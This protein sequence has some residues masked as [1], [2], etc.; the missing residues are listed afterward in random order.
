MGDGVYAS[1]LGA[2]LRLLRERG[3]VDLPR[4]GP[5]YR[6]EGPLPYRNGSVRVCLEIED[7]DFIE[8]PSI[9]ILEA[10]ADF[11]ALLP[12]VSA[13]G[14]FCYLA[15]GA[16]VLDRY[17]PEHAIAHCLD[18]ASEEL[19]RLASDPQYRQGEFQTEFGAS[20]SIGQLP[21]PW[22]VILGSIAP[23]AGQAN[24]F[25]MGPEDDRLLAVTS[26]DDEIAGL[27]QSRGWPA[28]TRA[29]ATCWIV[30]SDCMPTLIA[31]G[32]PRTVGEMFAWIKDWDRR[33]YGTIQTILGQRGYL[34]SSIVLFLVQSPAG[35]F[36]FEFSLDEGKRKVFQRKPTLMRQ[37]LHGRGSSCQISRL[38]VTEIG[39][40][41]VHSR[42]LMFPSLKDKRITLVGCGA[43][44]GYLA[45]A[46]VKLGAGSGDGELVLVDR[47]R[48]GAENIGRHYL[49]F[50]SF[51]VSKVEALKQALTAQFPLSRITTRNRD[52]EPYVDLSGDLVID[53]AGEE[54]LSES[55]NYHRQQVPAARRPPLLHVWVTGNGECVQSLWQDT[56]KFACYR[57]LRQND[58]ARTPRFS[59]LPTPE[60]VRI[61]GCQA[62]TPYAV[63]C[64]MSAAAL[65]TDVIIDWLRNG[66]PSPRFRTRIVENSELR[67]LKSQDLSPLS[68]CPA[69]AKL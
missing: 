27:C 33:A 49:G 44:G 36:G 40:D 39:V 68:G 34:A 18:R 42:N 26:R 64:P 22:N 6:F 25:L 20:W 24:A 51:R 9:R 38:S 37:S 4:K 69:C 45:Q 43:I 8:Y 35:W 15:E 53:A 11:P 54:A 14:G 67:K 2:T 46:L 19:D 59:I 58:A 57:C 62:F 61:L 28:P 1:G 3:F 30:R 7:W 50:E 63:S 60:E 23:G 52:A 12:H 41:Y 32:L 13:I 65:A 16:L 29:A 5:T 56:Q 31:A 55:L 48:L 10:P 66:D 17:H 47:D 21:L